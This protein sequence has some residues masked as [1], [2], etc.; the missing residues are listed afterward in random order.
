MFL[1]QTIHHSTTEKSFRF[2]HV[3]SK[4][5][6]IVQENC[7]FHITQNMVKNMWGYKI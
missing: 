3:K 4:N 6:N 7:N 1:V 2:K 5:S